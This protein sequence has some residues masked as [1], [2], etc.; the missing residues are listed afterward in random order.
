M[1]EMTTHEREQFFGV[2]ITLGIVL[3]FVLGS[4]LAM[5]IGDDVLDALNRLLDRISG[6]DDR[7]NFELL[8]Q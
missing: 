3:G 7:V 6:R 8:L 1:G 2:G 5:R 4:L